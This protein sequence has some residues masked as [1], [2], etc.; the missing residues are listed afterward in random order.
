VQGDS[1]NQSF[2]RLFTLLRAALWSK[3]DLCDCLDSVGQQV[4]AF[5][6]LLPRRTPIFQDS[7]SRSVGQHQTDKE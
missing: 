3:I 2:T 5:D 1:W 4:D 6:T 7:L